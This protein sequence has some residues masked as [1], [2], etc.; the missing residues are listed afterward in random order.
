MA[1]L[2]SFLFAVTLWVQVPQWSD[3]WSI[4]LLMFLIHLATGILL[5]P[6]IPLERDST[7]KPHRGIQ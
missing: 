7:G 5:M 2:F 4:V 1:H 3:D 6:T